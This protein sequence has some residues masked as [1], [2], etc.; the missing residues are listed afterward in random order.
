MI[1]PVTAYLALGSNLD[2]LQYIPQALQLLTQLPEAT[3]IAESRWYHTRPFGL[4]N[5][6]AFINLAVALETQL[7][8]LALLT[9]TQQIENQLGRVRTIANGPRT[10]DIDL[11]LIGDAVSDD[12]LLKLPH[13]GLLER[14]FMLIPVLDIAPPSLREP[15]S[16]QFLSVF[17]PAVRYRQI[18]SCSTQ[19]RSNDQSIAVSH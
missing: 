15:R 18:I 11:V 1:K 5:Q 12:P 4:F 17:A 6:P 19:A 3:L 10:I 2:P 8:P 14:D 7:T 16:G 13:P 9:H